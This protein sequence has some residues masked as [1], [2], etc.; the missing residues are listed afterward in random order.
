MSEVTS[1]KVGLVRLFARA[2][3][4]WTHSW[5]DPHTERYMRRKLPFG[6]WSDA[7][8]EADRIS[9]AVAQGAGFGPKLRGSDAVAVLDA[10]AEAVAHTGVRERTLLDHIARRNRFLDW[11]RAERPGVTGWGDVDAK[12]VG[13]FIG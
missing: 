5:W 7:A 1:C 9:K 2:D 6:K 8:A 13:D 4:T 10:L 12:A 11:L 3:G